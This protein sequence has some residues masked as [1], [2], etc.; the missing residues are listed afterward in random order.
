MVGWEDKERGARGQCYFPGVKPINRWVGNY[1][2][3]LTNHG[4]E[5]PGAV[6]LTKCKVDKWISG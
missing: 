4:V 2:N 1:W 5:V 3:N 6:P